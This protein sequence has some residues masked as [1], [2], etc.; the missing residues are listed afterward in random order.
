MIDWLQIAF[1]FLIL[2]GWLLYGMLLLI[3]VVW[4]LIKERNNVE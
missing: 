3:G 2:L 4:Y 1:D